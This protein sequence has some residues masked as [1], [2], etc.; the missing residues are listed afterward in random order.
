[1]VV[2]SNFFILR[3]I[4]KWNSLP[5]DGGEHTN[6]GY[7]HQETES[8]AQQNLKD[9]RLNLF[10]LQFPYL[11]YRQV[12]FIIKLDRGKSIS[13]YNSDKSFTLRTWLWNF[14]ALPIH[15]IIIFTNGL[16]IPISICFL[17][18]VVVFIS[19]FIYCQ[20][21][22]SSCHKKKGDLIKLSIV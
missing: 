17:I 10:C 8:L 12:Y 2:R 16:M 13:F 4:D 5:S 7:F 1:M 6:I 3:L 11:L 21:Q 19:F 15:L 14:I 20:P 22:K 9:N 18:G